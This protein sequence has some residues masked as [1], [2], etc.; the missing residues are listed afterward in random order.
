MEKCSPSKRRLVAK[1]VVAVDPD[2]AGAQGV[3]HLHRL[4]DVAGVHGCRKTVT[5]PEIGEG[6]SYI[7]V[8]NHC[9]YVTSLE[10]N[11]TQVK[12][13]RDQI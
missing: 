7:S 2:G 8:I 5:V 13:H 9:S 3:A 10:Q 4:A 1:H 12:Y 11:R 6:I